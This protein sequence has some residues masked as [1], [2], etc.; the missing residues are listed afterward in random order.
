LAFF[1][2]SLDHGLT[3]RSAFARDHRMEDA[4]PLRCQTWGIILVRLDSQRLLAQHHHP[5]FDC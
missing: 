4:F 1:A 3:C 5:L 2:S